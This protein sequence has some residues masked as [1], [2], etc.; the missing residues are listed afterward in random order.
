MEEKR[1]AWSEQKFRRVLTKAGRT[2]S[3]SWGVMGTRD[4]K[5]GEMQTV[6]A[7]N[8]D[9]TETFA[10]AFAFEDREMVAMLC[11]NL[12]RMA[13]RIHKGEFGT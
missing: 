11:A 2:I 1:N 12:M 8:D 4:K 6:L 3:C 9:E 13:D 10:Y 5:T 7:F